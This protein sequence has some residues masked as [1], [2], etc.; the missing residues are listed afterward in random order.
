MNPFLI[1]DRIRDLL[2]RKRWSPERA[3]GARGEDVAMRFLQKNGYVIVARN[4]RPRSGKGEVDLIG[5]EAGVLAFIEVKT[6]QSDE[7]GAPERAVHPEK[8]QHV[9]RA[10]QSYT[11][12]AK[13][14]W[15]VVRFDVVTVLAGTQPQVELYRNAFGS[16]EAAASRSTPYAPAP[17]GSYPRP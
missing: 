4:Y 5:W 6:R 2:H 9:I 11:R 13:V 12:R 7:T 8:Q 17:S 15:D 1:L 10:A 16:T 3:L 14:N